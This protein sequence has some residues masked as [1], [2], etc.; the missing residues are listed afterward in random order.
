MP[1]YIIGVMA[2]PDAPKCKHCARRFE[3]DTSYMESADHVFLS[4]RFC[5]RI[6]A[7]AKDHEAAMSKKQL[8]SKRKREKADRQARLF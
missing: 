8:A 2:F 1:K 6:T 4:C 5:L 7:F 3:H